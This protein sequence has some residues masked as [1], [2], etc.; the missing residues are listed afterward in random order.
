MKIVF[1][2]HTRVNVPPGTCYGWTDVPVADTFEAEAAVTKARLH[3][4]GTFDAV[5]SSPLTR[6]RLL[7]AYCGYPD[8]TLD[9]RLKELNMGRWEMQRYEEIEDPFLQQ[10]YDDYLHVSTPDGESFCQ[11]FERVSSFINSLRHAP[12]RQVAVFAHAGIQVA[13]SIFFKAFPFEEA[14]HHVT[15]FEYGGIV[16]YEL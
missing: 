14:W 16:D 4:Y 7:A 9:D 8:A 6:A 10:W 3:T 1:V 15:E 12:Y 2:R 5:F 11:Q 13:A